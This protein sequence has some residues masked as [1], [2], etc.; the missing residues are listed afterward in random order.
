MEA[1]D[2]P[3]GGGVVWFSS[4]MGDPCGMFVEYVIMPLFGSSLAEDL[5][6]GVS[7]SGGLPRQSREEVVIAFG[8]EYMTCL[9]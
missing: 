6:T 8:L 2:H 3:H 9:P 1:G 5:P 4:S 7:K